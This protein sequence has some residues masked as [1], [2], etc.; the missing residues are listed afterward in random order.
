MVNCSEC[1]TK[2]VLKSEIV[3][4]INN[5]YEHLDYKIEKLYQCPKCKNIEVD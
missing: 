1:K 3:T 5:R 2:M 4:D